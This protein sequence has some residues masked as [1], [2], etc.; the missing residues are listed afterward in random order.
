VTVYTSARSVNEPR[1]CVLGT[2]TMG[3]GMA[4][5]LAGAGLETRAWNRTVARAAPLSDAGIVVHTDLPD[6]VRDADVIV[7]MLWDAAT[8]E[9]VLRGAETAWASDAVLLQTSTVGVEGAE[10]LAGVAAE[11]GLRY[12]DAPV[13]GTRQPAE[14]GTLVVLASGPED[15]R[16]LL[17]P[18]LGAI[19]SDVLWLG[20]AG[21]GSRL[22]LATNAFVVNVTAALAESMQ[23][24]AGLGIDPAAFLD[25][26]AGGSL[27]SPYVAKKGRAMVT[28]DFTPAFAVDGGLKDSRL[29]AA[30]AATAEVDVPLT[31]ATESLLLALSELGH[32]AEDI[33]ALGRAVSGAV[34]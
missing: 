5:N 4:R 26:I 1:V 20:D 34:R 21:A 17:A 9:E 15:T 32:G 24:A 23:I 28:G 7:T 8:V 31:R 33:A 11:L 2:G 27:Q 13:Q 10:R 16:E 22:K 6:A 18:V 3:A 29:I 25:A 19:G 30:A 12:V 14:Q